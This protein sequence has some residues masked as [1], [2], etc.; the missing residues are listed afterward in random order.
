MNPREIKK[1]DFYEFIYERQLIWSRRFMERRPYPWTENTIL[2]IYKFCNNYRELDKGSIYLINTIINNKDLN[3]GQ[4]IL[5]C[6]IYRRFNLVG[7]FEWVG[8]PILE[9]KIFPFDNLVYKLD[10]RKKKGFTL[11]N[12]AYIITQAV[13]YRKSGRKEKHIQ[14]LYVF[15]D[16]VESGRIW[17]I[18][19]M[20][21][22][23]DNLEEIHALLKQ[24]IF[25]M[26][27]FLAYQTCT[28]LTYFPEFKNKFKDVHTFVKMGPGSSP[29]IVLLFPDKVK[30]KRDPKCAEL[31][32]WLYENQQKY[33]EQL[34]KK[35]GKDWYK[36]YYS[37]AYAGVPYLSLSN[38]QNC[39]CEFRKFVMLQIDPNKKKRYYKP[40][41]AK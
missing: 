24:E 18:K 28:D 37:K 29:G 11:F 2:K 4:K 26:G 40:E 39:L 20:I 9:T 34:K 41:G 15:K 35:T 32:V 6:L 38:I 14:Q 27:D 3:L 21:A 30:N 13:Y 23:S 22:M 7:F 25:G 31:C 10:N 1:L 12:D 16:L 5:N 8:G 33:L 19:N 17:D 36:I